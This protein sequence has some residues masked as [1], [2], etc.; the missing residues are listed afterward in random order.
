MN[1][2]FNVQFCRLLMVQVNMGSKMKDNLLER[3][4]Y[5]DI[6]SL[7]GNKNR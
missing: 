3:I 6:L 7:D 1:P 2:V 5:L 4:D